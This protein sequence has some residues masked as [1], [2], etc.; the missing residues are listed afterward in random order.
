MLLLF[1]VY[2]VTAEFLGKEPRGG[3]AAE[4]GYHDNDPFTTL[5]FHLPSISLFLGE[6]APR[7]VAA[8]CG[9]SDGFHYNDPFTTLSFH[10]PSIY[11]PYPFSF[12]TPPPLFF[13]FNYSNK[14]KFILFIRLRLLISRRDNI[15]TLWLDLENSNQLNS[16]QLNSHPQTK[17]KRK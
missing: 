17:S 16:T 2:W 12:V 9:Y 6:G 4:C 5:S 11:L 1:I 13:P 7:G 10:L 3:V 8:E 14:Y 15:D